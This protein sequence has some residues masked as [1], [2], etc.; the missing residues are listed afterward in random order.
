MTFGSL[1]TTLANS[2]FQFYV[3]RSSS[4]PMLYLAHRN[5]T[6]EGLVVP[7]TSVLDQSRPQHRNANPLNDSAVA[8]TIAAALD[9]SST[10]CAGII[11]QRLRCSLSLTQPKSDADA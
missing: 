10:E 4:A 8:F 5:R 9:G 3:S 2:V 6:A 11:T 7:D 1:Q